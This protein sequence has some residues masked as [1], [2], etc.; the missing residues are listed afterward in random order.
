LPVKKGLNGAMPAP[1]SSKDGSSCGIKEAL[2][3]IKCPR[4]AKKSKTSVL[5]RSL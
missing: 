3:N 1:I 5:I 2:G 4:A